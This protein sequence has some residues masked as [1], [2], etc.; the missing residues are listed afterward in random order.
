MRVLFDLKHPVDVHFFKDAIRI[1]QSRGHRVLI[2]SRAKDETEALLRRLGMEHVCLSQMAEGVVG[3]GVELVWR[4]VRLIRRMRR[5][6]PDVLVAKTGIS[7]AWAG[8]LLN[9]PSIVFEDTEFAWLQVALCAPFATVM[10]TGMGYGRRFPGKELRYRAPLHLA[11]THPG[12]FTPDPDVLRAH[13]VA[14]EEPYVVLRVKAWRAVHDLGVSGPSEQQLSRLV[15]EVARHARPVISSERGLPAGLE[16]YRNPVPVENAL[17]LLHFAR[18]Y[19]GEGSCMAA[20][21]VCLG[22]PAVFLSPAS[23]RGYLDALEERYGVVVTVRTV[24][25]AI[26]LTRRWATSPTPK[27]KAREA[28]RRLIEECEDPVRFILR[29]VERYGGS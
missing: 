29:V 6:R 17:D 13:G 21:A 20:E 4:T 26:E 7:I 19:V 9:V 12:R 11:Y 25:E 8:R 14:P 28:R 5:F 27:R 23:R 18:L 1:L 16:K 24:A 10:C 2:T 15:D 22:T 3:M